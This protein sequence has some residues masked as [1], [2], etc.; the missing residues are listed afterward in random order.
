M[1][2]FNKNSYEGEWDNDQVEGYGVYIWEKGQNYI[3]YWKNGKQNGQGL[4]LYQNKDI[5]DG[6][7]VENKKEGK[8]VPNIILNMIKG[9]IPQENGKMTKD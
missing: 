9:N 7:W 4:L 5:Y 8:G 2:Y 3:G 1:T 6:N